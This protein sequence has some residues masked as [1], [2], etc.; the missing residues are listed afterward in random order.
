LGDELL[1]EGPRVQ[2]TKKRSGVDI[3]TS[4]PSIPGGKRSKISSDILTLM[5]N[6]S[7][8]HPRVQLS[9][10]KEMAFPRKSRYDK[11]KNKAN[12][13]SPEDPQLVDSFT[14]LQI[15]DGRE[16]SIIFDLLAGIRPSREVNVS[17]KE[18]NPLII[19]SRD[20][21]LIAEE[22]SS[23]ILPSLGVSHPPLLSSGIDPNEILT[24]REI[25]ENPHS[26]AET[27]EPSASNE[28]DKGGAFSSQPDFMDDDEVTRFSKGHSAGDRIF[29]ANPDSS[30][31]S[32]N[33]TSG[34][35]IKFLGRE[36]NWVG[37]P[38]EAFA[39]LIPVS[40]APDAVALSR[41]ETM[42]K[43]FRYLVDVSPSD[44]SLLFLFFC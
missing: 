43:M 7:S 39:D 11:G 44:P 28:M 21:T 2:L 23:S 19:P 20:I 26:E 42:N 18:N 13:S 38:F 22:N 12:P 24:T 1:L 37:D 15:E 27:M 8:H 9:L 3:E 25:Q 32:N 16:K 36:I 41:K 6:E 40:P 34:E 31:L 33:R 29:A 30:R 14:L 5:S 4:R 10:P 35:S 17:V